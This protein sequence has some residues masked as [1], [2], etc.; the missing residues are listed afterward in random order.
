MQLLLGAQCKACSCRLA[1]VLL[2]NRRAGL[3]HALTLRGVLL[4]PSGVPYYAMHKILG[5]GSNCSPP[6]QPVE[7]R[8]IP[9]NSV[10]FRRVMHKKVL[11]TS[12]G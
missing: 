12:S 1:T 9:S 11:C 5:M 10:E 8:R 7:F 3:P 6:D 2:S 4:A